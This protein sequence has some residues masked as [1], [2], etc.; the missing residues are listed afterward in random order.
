MNWVIIENNEKIESNKIPT[1]SI[2]EIKLDFCKFNHRLI[3]FF[4]KQEFENV[5]LYVVLADDKIGKIYITSTL[6]LPEMKSYESTGVIFKNITGREMKKDDVIYER[7][8]SVQR[9]IT[10]IFASEPKTVGRY[11][12]YSEAVNGSYE[13][14]LAYLE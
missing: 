1:T 9:K 12:M 4:G 11:V 5:R 6:F 2:D 3:G 14:D 13:I 8:S 7:L 10:N